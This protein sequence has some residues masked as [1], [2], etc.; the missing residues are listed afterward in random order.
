MGIIIIGLVILTD[1]WSLDKRY[2]NDDK[3]VAKAVMNQQ[4]QPREVD[5]FIMR[6]RDPDFR[7]LDLTIPTFSSADAT[8]FHKTI[9][10]YHAAK[11]KR[12]QEVVDKQF[13]GGINQD[14]LDM[15]NTKY[16]ITTGKDG[17][18][19]SMQSNSTASGHAWFVESIQFV[20]NNDQEMQ[21]ISSFNPKKEAIVNQEFKQLIEGEKVG[22]PTNGQI[23][24]TSYHPDLLKYE[25]SVDKNVVAVFSEI[26]YPKGWKMYVDGEE[27][28]YFRANYL[29]RAAVLPAGNHKIEWKF[30]PTSY[31]LGENISLF[32][33]I[34]L[35]LILA[36]AIYR[37]I[38]CKQPA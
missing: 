23:K 20:A 32:G 31:F 30:E 33:S 8:A 35:S 10:G 36:I 26:W 34:L 5:E 13:T 21:A 28:S 4:A 22:I 18:T 25:Y 9:G 1:L 2:L 14:I 15:L 29:L 27:R 17:K 11:L 19:A 16:F 12:F 3:F 7:V 38:A 24:L 6:D 37:E